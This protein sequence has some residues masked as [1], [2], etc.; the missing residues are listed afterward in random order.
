MESPDYTIA[1]RH[2]P[3]FPSLMFSIRGIS[4]SLLKFF[5][6]IYHISLTWNPCDFDEK[7]F[8][9]FP[10]PIISNLL[11]S[12]TMTADVHQFSYRDEFLGKF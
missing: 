10:R 1:S 7:L 5:W 12:V 4:L 9:L 2:S 6:R 8:F 11:R 3:R